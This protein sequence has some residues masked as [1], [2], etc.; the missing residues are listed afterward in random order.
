MNPTVV[1]PSLKL[2]TVYWAKYQELSG[3]VFDC[4]TCVNVICGFYKNI[5][6]FSDPSVK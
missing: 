3:L 1:K 2:S 5:K 4:H 6:N